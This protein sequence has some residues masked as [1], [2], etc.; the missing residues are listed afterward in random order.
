MQ[1]YHPLNQK[2]YVHGWINGI[3]PKPKGNYYRE[4][5]FNRFNHLPAIHRFASTAVNYQSGLCIRSVF[6]TSFKRILFFD[7]KEAAYTYEFTQDIKSICSNSSNFLILTTD[8][9]VYSLGV[10]AKGGL[11]P[12]KDPKKCKLSEPRLIDFFVRKNLFVEEIKCSEKT[13]YY[14]CKGKKVY[15]NGYKRTGS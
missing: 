7:S 8:G 11:L 4:A 10:C 6:Q 14:L 3:L 15:L 2:T 5:K 9:N 13:N 1:T 12:F